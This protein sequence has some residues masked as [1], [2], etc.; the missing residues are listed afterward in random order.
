MIK[1]YDDFIF[2]HIEEK[3]EKTEEE[4]EKGGQDELLNIRII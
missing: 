4:N 1:V 2:I 3:E